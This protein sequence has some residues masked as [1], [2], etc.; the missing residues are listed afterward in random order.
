[1][2]AL[3]HAVGINHDVAEARAGRDVDLDAVELD[4]L[5]LGQQ[6]LVRAEPGFRLR[7]PGARGGAPPLDLA[8]EGAAARRLRLLRVRQ[9]LLLLLEPG[10]VVALERDA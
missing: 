1:G 4:V 5:L 6:A 9:P 10:G 7:V 3:A 8:H 2:K